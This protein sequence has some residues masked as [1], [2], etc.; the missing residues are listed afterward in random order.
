MPKKSYVILFVLGLL[1]ATGGAFLQTNPGYMDA[2]YY[3]YGG[4][5]IAAGNGWSEMFLW[6]YLDDPA[7]LPHPG[8]TYWM[9]L[10]SLV[11]A[12]GIKLFSGAQ[13][14]FEAAQVLFILVSALVAPVTAGLAYQLSG[15]RARRCRQGSS[16]G[17]TWQRRTPRATCCPRW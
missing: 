7:G 6:N 2:A 16:P 3:F 1:M 9:P 15:P 5:Q 14:A 13:S 10:T 12:G 8:F 11:A 4:E 17:R